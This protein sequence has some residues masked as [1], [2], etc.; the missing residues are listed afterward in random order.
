MQVGARPGKT[1]VGVGAAVLAVGV[2]IQTPSQPSAQ[3][4]PTV[5]E[6]AVLE[7]RRRAVSKVPPSTSIL[8]PLPL[9]KTSV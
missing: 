6:L 8:L 9:P 7:Y 2:P 1:T 3:P 5:G 4:P